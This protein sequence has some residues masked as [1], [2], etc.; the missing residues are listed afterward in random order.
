MKAHASSARVLAALVGLVSAAA[1]GGWCGAVGGCSSE[2]R[3]PDNPVNRALDGKQTEETRVK[4]VHEAFA[5]AV[6]ESDRI[7]VRTELTPQLWSKD[8]APALKVAIV[9]ELLAEKSERSAAEIREELRLNLPLQSSREVVAVVCKAAAERGWSEFI[10]AIVRTWAAPLPPIKDEDRVERAAIAA[11]TPDSPGTMGGVEATVFGVFVTPPPD[12]TATRRMKLEERYR[13]AAWEVLSRLD[14]IGER[15]VALLESVPAGTP[16]APRAPFVEELL[17]ARRELGI[18]PAYGE[19]LLWLRRLRDGKSAAN[20]AWWAEASA[21][22]GSLG[23]EQKAGLELRHVEAIRWASKHR[24]AW[25]GST[26]DQLAAAITEKLKDRP[27][28]EATGNRPSGR[29]RILESYKEALP[30]MG[31]ADMLTMLVVGE[32]IESPGVAESL[33]TYAGYDERDLKTE[34]GGL[35]QAVEGGERPF[36]AT[37]YA[38]R[39][40]DRYD[41]RRF[42]ASQ[43]MVDA[44]DRALVHWHFHVAERSNASYAGPS[45]EDLD[46]ATRQGRTCVVF[47]SLDGRRL[48][49][50]YFQRG[51]IIVD[52]GVVRKPGE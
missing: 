47:T 21:A 15:R 18:L 22:L 4:S 51:G 34:Y 8:A 32:A 43:D 37:L 28:H 6:S 23:A 1:V 39:P 16:A 33:F 49:A 7:G 30:R 5:R 27:V 14:P 10:P 11:L 25:I 36:I 13:L 17:A 31:W 46:Y 26:K 50:D 48:N 45:L 40:G 19:E 44:S 38:P 20:A 3:V 2:P 12:T 9:E 29:G 24:S 35:V 42:V 52:L 41:D